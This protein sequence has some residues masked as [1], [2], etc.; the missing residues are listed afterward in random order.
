MTAIFDVVLEFFLDRQWRFTPLEGRTVLQMS[1]GTNDA[2]WDCFADVKESQRQFIFY[3]VVPF[4]ADEETRSEV[5]EFITRANY[6]L[7]LGNFEMDFDDGEIRFKSSIDV[8]SDPATAV[9]VERVVDAN[10]KAMAKYLPGLV[11]VKNGAPAVDAIAE[12][13]IDS[14][15]DR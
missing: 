11:A 7:I 2:K 15:R 1:V 5:A 14:R 3:S 4:L 8:G 9:L 6:G 13:E 12:I 10:V